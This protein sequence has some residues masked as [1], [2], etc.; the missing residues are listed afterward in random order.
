MSVWAQLQIQTVKAFYTAVTGSGMLRIRSGR[1]AYSALYFCY[2]RYLEDPFYKLAQCHPELFRGGHIVDVGAN[3]GYTAAVFANAITPGF[4]VFAFEPED[5]NFRMLGEL[6][7]QRGIAD[8]VVPVQAAVGAE[9]GSAMLKVNPRHPGDHSVITEKSR[10][11]DAPKRK[12]V[13]VKV[14][15]FLRDRGASTPVALIKID[16]QG[17]EMAVCQGMVATLEA[18]PAAVVCLEYSPDSMRTLGFEPTALLDWFRQRGYSLRALDAHGKPG[19]EIP[20][21]LGRDAYL[22][23]CFA[24]ESARGGSFL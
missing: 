19:R 14:D 3:I 21:A 8:I 16:V 20:A 10:E 13:L 9:E 6:V 4:K 11:P 23:L 1:R 18:N 22:N 17:Y 7:A 15:N 24:K 12:V 2:K 5:L